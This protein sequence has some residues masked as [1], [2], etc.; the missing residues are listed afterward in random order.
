MIDFCI[1]YKVIFTILHVL[2][3]VVGMGSALVSD[4]LFN[5]FSQDKYLDTGEQKTLN[6]LSSIVWYSLIG[7]ILSGIAIFSSNIPKY[8]NS[9]KFLLKMGIMMILLVNGYIIHR[10]ISPFMAKRNFLTAVKQ[11]TH[12]RIA[13][14]CGA[15]SVSSWVIICILGMLSALPV[16]LPIGIV[17]YFGIIITGSIVALIV[18]GQTFR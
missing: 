5:F 1:H 3:V 2:T 14:I 13:F 9:E 15:V 16:S 18:E 8:L 17:I 10:Y 7:I 4:L 11:K 12:R 6:F